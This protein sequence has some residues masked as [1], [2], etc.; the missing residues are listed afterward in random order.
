VHEASRTVMLPGKAIGELE[1]EFGALQQ[2]ARAEL[3]GVAA[4][5]VDLRYRGQGYELNVGW[6]AEHPE[7]S[8]EAFHRLHEER[9]GFCD[10]SKAMQIV[11]LRLRMTVAAEAYEPVRRELV[12]GNGEVA[13]Y[14]E[15]A[16]DFEGELVR[17]DFYRREK[18]VPG[19]VIEGPAMITEYT[20]ATVLPPECRLT[21]DGFGN[22]VIEV[23][24]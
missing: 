19:D 10:R 6:D 16:I 15:K 2:R 7:R 18:L 8:I 17:A 9:Y 21:V 1:D 14:G 22:L 24:Q 12:A 3:D 20:S 4:T 13:L 11:N 5:S 23:G